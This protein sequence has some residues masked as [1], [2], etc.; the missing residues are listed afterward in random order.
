MKQNLKSDHIKDN[1]KVLCHLAVFVGEHSSTMGFIKK[2]GPTKF[3]SVRQNLEFC[4]TDVWQNSRVF[5]Q[6]CFHPLNGYFFYNF[7]RTLG[8]ALQHFLSDIH[9]KCPIVRQV[10]RILTPLVQWLLI[11]ASLIMWA[12]MTLRG[13]AGSL[14]ISRHKNGC[15]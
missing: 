14:P 9:K 3:C 6:H 1:N 10:R 12:T 13:V 5:R 8:P 15:L 7:C 2:F 11:L 4:Q